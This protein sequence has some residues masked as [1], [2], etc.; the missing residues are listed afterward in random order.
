[1]KKLIILIGLITITVGISAQVETWIP[2]ID[3]SG[4]VA[5]DTVIYPKRNEIRNSAGY[6]MYVT[7]WTTDLDTSVTF[8]FGGS[9]KYIKERI[10]GFE[11]IANDSLPYTFLKE[12]NI[13]VTNGDTTYQK[14]FDFT[15]PIK[16]AI[17]GIWLRK[18]AA[19]SGTIGFD[20]ILSKP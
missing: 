16:T 19:T 13:V 18:D 20:V 11:Q 4:M 3:I 6:Y 5:D 7:A 2:R 17:P 8:S 9:N 15:E 10:Y 12:S 14:S 1:M